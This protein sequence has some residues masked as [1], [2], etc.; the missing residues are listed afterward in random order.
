[1]GEP[2][3]VS[4]QA[5]AVGGTNDE[6]TPGRG[7]GANVRQVTD[8]DLAGLTRRVLERLHPRP[9]GVQLEVEQKARLALQEITTAEDVPLTREHRSR[10]AR[11]A[12][13]AV[14]AERRA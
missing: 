7:V 5:F 12:W 2:P 10:I 4:Q 1:M 11:D 13:L 14:E 8:D 6:Q 3:L 9:T